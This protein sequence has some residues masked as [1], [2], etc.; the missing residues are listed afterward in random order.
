MDPGFFYPAPCTTAPPWR[1]FHPPMAQVS[2]PHGASSTLQR[3]GGSS[4]YTLLAIFVDCDDP[5]IAAL[6]FFAPKRVMG[7]SSPPPMPVYVQLERCQGPISCTYTGG[8]GGRSRLFAFGS[9]ALNNNPARR[10]FGHRDTRSSFG[11]PNGPMR[12][13]GTGMCF[14]H[15]FSTKG[16]SPN[17]FDYICR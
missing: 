8:A 16:S 4:H 11:C 6:R 13:I 10:F 1:R 5:R 2:T 17:K 15:R 14:R 9:I 3:N 12:G 7:R